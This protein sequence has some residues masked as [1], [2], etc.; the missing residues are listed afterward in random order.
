MNQHQQDLFAKVISSLPQL[1]RNSWSPK[2]SQSDN[3]TNDG[4]LNTKTTFGG[5]NPFR[6]DN[7]V[8]PICDECNAHKGFVCQINI[9]KLPSLF[10]EKI[11][12]T[13]GLFQL[14]Y[15][16]ECMPLNCFKDMTFIPT[17]EFVPS[18]KSLSAL[19]VSKKK[20]K[21]KEMP[22]HLINYLEDYT[23]DVPQSVV[24]SDKLDQIM[25]DSWIENPL[26]EIPLVCEFGDVYEEKI[27]RIT[28][29]GSEDMRDFYECLEDETLLEENTG[30]QNIITPY[31]GIKLGG[32]IRW[33][34]YT[35]YPTCPDCKVEMNVVFLQLEEDPVY[36]FMWGDCGTGHVTL[37]P[38]CGRPGLSWACS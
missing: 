22:L 38:R 7:F 32:F 20:V 36:Q 21:K 23:E 13:S 12:R 37:C 1:P 4:N 34:Q 18:L 9:E 11:N 24:L 8:W 6:P 17:S 27:K 19:K 15:C 35:E 31:S 5:N 14:F 26:M 30:F 33:C 10:K 3:P 28:N 16:L 29:L 2:Q 25:V